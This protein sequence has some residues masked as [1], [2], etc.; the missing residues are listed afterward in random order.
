MDELWLAKWGGGKKR[1]YHY[2]NERATI[3]DAGTFKVGQIWIDVII[4]VDLDTGKKKVREKADFFEKF[5]C[6]ETHHIEED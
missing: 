1:E 6:I 2:K 3:H 5:K 4:Y